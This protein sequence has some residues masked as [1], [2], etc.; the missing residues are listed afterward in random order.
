MFRRI[1]PLVL[2]I[3]IAACGKDSP[4]SPTPP[5]TPTAIIRMLGDLNFG[6]VEVGTEATRPF[7]VINDGTAPL[8]V[9]GLTIGSAAQFASSW[10]SGTVEPGRAADVLLR[11]RPTASGDFSG[12]L[13]VNGNQ[14][15]GTNTMAVTARG[16]RTGPLWTRSGTGADVFDM[17]TAVGRVRITATY[18]GR[19]ENFIVHVGGSGVVNVILG[20]CSVAD[21]VNYDG[22]HL[23]KGGTTEVLH[24]SGVNWTFTE[25]R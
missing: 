1:L 14:V 12:T 22:T 4:S 3:V 24:A 9:T 11:F 10:T 25:V 7:Q 18:T 17:P 5:S 6:D 16:V 23:V 21:S 15:S 13:R 8:V 2:I 20:T 19:C